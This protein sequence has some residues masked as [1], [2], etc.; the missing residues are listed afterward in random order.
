[1]KRERRAGGAKVNLKNTLTKP[2][3]RSGNTPAGKK[4]NKRFG[5]KKKKARGGI[6]NGG[7]ERRLLLHSRAA[8]K[9]ATTKNN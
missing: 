1:M 3:I 4:L 8:H 6:Q 9:D 7:T 5:K 2:N